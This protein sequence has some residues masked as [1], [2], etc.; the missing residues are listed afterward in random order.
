MRRVRDAKR[1]G[2]EA[3]VAGGEF[4]AMDSELRDGGKGGRRREVGSAAPDWLP[5]RKTEERANEDEQY[6]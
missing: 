1:E 6:E 3:E 2:E 4:E 5:R